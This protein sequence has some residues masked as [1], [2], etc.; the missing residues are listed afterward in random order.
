MRSRVWSTLD[1]C[2]AGIGGLLGVALDASLFSVFT[3][4]L[5]RAPIIAVCRS[6]SIRGGRQNS[7]QA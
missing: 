5:Q 6:L 2:I 7:I 3:V 1:L 4:H